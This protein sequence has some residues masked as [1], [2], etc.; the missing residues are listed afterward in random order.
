MPLSCLLNGSIFPV[1]RRARIYSARFFR[2][3]RI[4]QVEILN[5]TFEPDENV[6]R[7]AETHRPFAQDA[8]RTM[9]VRYS[10]VIARWVAEREG[11]KVTVD[12]SVT[13][14]HPMADDAW[15]MRH[16]LQYGPEAEILNPPELRRLLA[17]RLESM[18][19]S[20]A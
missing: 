13:I 4:E 12:G 3:D 1:S 10:P 20:K 9:T 5:E 16:V 14:V 11:V 6:T 7:R 2:L 8:D 17:A 18:R 15:A 19:G